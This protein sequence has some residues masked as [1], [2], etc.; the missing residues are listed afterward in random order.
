MKKIAVLIPDFFW[1]SIPYDG[2]SLFYFLSKKF[3]CD[4]MM[5]VDDIRLNKSIFFDYQKYYFDNKEFCQNTKLIK[6]NDWNSFY[7]KSKE[8]DLIISNVHLA[9]KG[10]RAELLSNFNSNIQ[11]KFM[12]IDIGG[13]DVLTQ[14]KRGNYFCVKGPIWKTWLEKMGV[15]SKFVF[16]TGSPHYDLYHTKPK[17]EACNGLSSI[18]FHDKYKL[19]SK[20][21]KLLIAPSNPSSHQN[22]FTKNLNQIQDLYN[23][24][25]VK[26]YEVLIK[27]YPN[28]YV[29]YD[30]QKIYTGIYKRSYSR[31]RPQY[32]II[33]KLIPEATVIDSQDHFIALTCSDKLFNMS[34]SHFAWETIFT[35]TKSYSMNYKN[36][37]YYG[38]A[39][40][41]PDFVKLPDEFVNININK[42]EDIFNDGLDCDKQKC[43][44]YINKSFSLPNI[45][46]AVE[47]VLTYE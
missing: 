42:I 44:E 36:Q 9:P 10:E 2:L 27:T 39:S 16:N 21:K 32:E 41:L 5:F 6:L 45:S 38:G 15:D 7:E 13:S 37:S 46:N 33:K 11:C 35:K 22:Q 8:Y 20:K 17:P 40:Y 14:Y 25:V 4:L 12:T 43:L 30:E 47:T 28:D 24:A 31:H 23:L 19:N 1:S 29:F 34:G 26:G 3:N 18:K